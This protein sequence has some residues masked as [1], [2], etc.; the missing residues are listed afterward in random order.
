MRTAVVHPCDALAIEGALACA[1][2][3]LIVPVLVG[4]EKKIRAAANAAG[5]DVSHQEIVDAPHSHAAAALAAE[6]A[7]AGKV[8]ALMKG[9]LHS[10][11][12]LHEVTQP[13]SGLHTQRR[14]SHGFV[15]DVPAYAQSLVISDAVVNVAPT[16]DEKRDIVQNAIDLAHAIGV[17]E[18]RVALLSAVETVSSRIPSTLDAA[19]L[20]KMADRGQIAGAS[21]DGPLALDDAISS[22]AALEKTIRSSVAGCANVLIVPDLDSGNMLAKA[23][24]LLANAALAGVVLGARIPIVLTSRADS[25]ETRIASAAIGLLLARARVQLH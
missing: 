5:I 16:L 8:E 25:V 7:R 10:D 9:S 17:E 1:D 15:A 14:I 18:V 11:E 2:A 24:G 3:G 12:L 6:M 19:A 20:C 23:L 13:A 4:N 21:V 22:A